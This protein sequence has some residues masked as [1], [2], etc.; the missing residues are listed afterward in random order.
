MKPSVITGTY[1]TDG[2]TYTYKA[3]WWLRGNVLHWQSKVWMGGDVRGEP[4]GQ[5]LG[6]KSL[7]RDPSEHVRALIE[8]SIETRAG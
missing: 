4:S 8:T 2:Q 3:H 1:T 5:L 6:A 7:P